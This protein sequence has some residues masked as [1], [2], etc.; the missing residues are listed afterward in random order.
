MGV[1]SARL[2]FV[3]L[4]DGVSMRTL[5][6]RTVAAS[7]AVALAAV[8]FPAV[9]TPPAAV[10]DA[11]AVVGWGPDGISSAWTDLPADQVLVAVEAADAATV[12]LTYGG[13]VTVAS[14]ATAVPELQQVP[15][16]VAGGTATAISTGAQMAAAV[17]DDGSVHAWGKDPSISIPGYPPIQNP[18]A[19]DIPENL[20][21]LRDVA[22]G[23]VAGAHAAIGTT[24]DGALVKWGQEWTGVPVPEGGG[25]DDVAVGQKH[26]YALK[27]GSLEFI[28]ESG[29]NKEAIPAE[30]ADSAVVDVA[31]RTNGGL[32]LLENGDVYSWGERVPGY[33]AVPDAV[34]AA[35][36]VDIDAKGNRNIALDDAGN[37][38]AWGITSGAGNLY[39]DAIPAAAQNAATRSVTAGNNHF[40]V[41][42]AAVRAL[43]VPT[44]EGTPQVGE[45]LTA[46][47]PEFSG[48]SGDID[49]IWYAGESEVEG[50]NGATF[51]PT[52][53]QQDAQIS[54]AARAAAG[55]EPV[56]SER[57]APT[58][59]VAGGDDG[60]QPGEPADVVDPYRPLPTELAGTLKAWGGELAMGTSA[61][62]APKGHEDKRF[63]RVGSNGVGFIAGGTRGTVGLTTDGK[64]LNWASFESTDGF[65]KNELP[66]PLREGTF[67]DFAMNGSSIVAITQ[68][69]ALVASS[70]PPAE[71]QPETWAS[72]PAELRTLPGGASPVVHVAIA[73]SHGGFATHEDGTVTAWGRNASKDSMP[74]DLADV[75]AVVTGG[76]QGQ[77]AAAILKDGSVRA[78]APSA[79][80]VPAEVAA[81]P[82][83]SLWFDTR[84]AGLALMAD[85]A[86]RSWGSWGR[87]AFPE[88]LLAQPMKSLAVEAGGSTT[89]TDFS[90]VSAD[91]T[92]Y[93]VA[94]GAV[95]KAP[96]AVQSLAVATATPGKSGANSRAPHVVIATTEDDGGGTDGGGTDGGGTDGGGTDGGGTDGGG[97]DGGGTD[98]GGTDGGGTDGGGE[99]PPRPDDGD[100]ADL[101]DKIQIQGS[102]TVAPGTILD[103]LVGEQYA[104][105]DVT[106]YMFSTPRELGTMTVDAQ[107]M[108]K[109]KVPEDTEAGTHRLAVYDANGELIGWQDFTVVVDGVGGPGG[110]GGRLPGTGATSPEFLA[111][112][113]AI[114]LL[115]GAVT[116]G[117]SWRRRQL[118]N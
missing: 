29:S 57:S 77:S 89:S 31:A 25:Y 83:R 67:K 41:T 1:T 24:A 71:G 39:G 46:T 33:N 94:G 52:A 86:L 73:G 16:A 88:D 79:D 44:I 70:E 110:P 36:I 58:E 114:V 45:P 2:I 109:V 116:I 118:L 30:V 90:L 97:T 76:N 93:N 63:I 11:G 53:Q 115:A 10:S 96:E 68:Q 102:T 80:F 99:N 17:L 69:G 38:Y 72:I 98:G 74:A 108:I 14:G 91:G 22:I 103:V 42:Q 20:P 18:S 15:E 85:G 65:V 19:L 92:V 84:G 50:Q 26:A 9:A 61:A 49:F 105:Q 66:A 78:W 60:E 8:A 12:G 100:S 3:V 6:R 51:A 82:V 28:G 54:V 4:K 43:G 75:H 87:G 23:A 5:A 107:G 64:M 104:G 32:A 81:G 21:A 37:V 56:L 47:A 34:A 111:P 35:T 48:N 112:L 7:A 117:A 95:E 13:K 106:A 27:G 113:G 55:G 59:P 62:E 101:K 40:L